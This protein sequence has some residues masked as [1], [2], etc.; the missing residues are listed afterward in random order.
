MIAL[1][2]LVALVGPA[3]AGS[4]ALEPQIRLHA[5]LNVVA[6]PLAPFGVTGGLDARLTRLINIDVGG[7]GSPVP[8]PEEE[9]QD[10]ANPTD[11]FHLR[12]GVYV[13]PGIR[14]PHSQPKAF[15]WDVFIRGGAGVV[16]TANLRPGANLLDEDLPYP[17]DPAPAGFAGADLT[18]RGAKLGVRLSGRAWMYE[19]T[20]EALGEAYFHAQGQF[21]VEGT[22]QF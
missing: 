12:H 9:V 21:G 6:D 10:Q 20:Q 19:V 1:S 14:I 2:L 17:V 16:W 8:I 11:Y 18:L 7:F 15:A 22:W 3:L 13:A 4:A 5:G